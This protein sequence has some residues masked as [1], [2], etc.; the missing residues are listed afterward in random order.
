MNYQIV[1]YVVVVVVAAVVD[2]DDEDKY[3]R[4]FVDD[5][6]GDCRS[7]VSFVDRFHLYH[8]EHFEL[9]QIQLDVFEQIASVLLLFDLLDHD[10]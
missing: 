8:D 2:D 1:V 9:K 5:F 3:S 7:S 10:H 4:V 6:S